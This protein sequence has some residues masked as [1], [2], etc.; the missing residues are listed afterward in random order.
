MILF[1][2]TGSWGEVSPLLSLAHKFGGKM[3]CGPEWIDRASAYIPSI[4]IGS[5]IRH[6]YTI[7]GF[8]ESLPLR[9]LFLDLWRASEGCTAIVAAFFLWPA[10]IVAELRG[11]PCYSTTVTPLYFMETGQV[12]PA[13]LAKVSKELSTLRHEVGL[14]ERDPLIPTR[15]IGLFPS[16]LGGPV[17]TIGYP[18]LADPNE[19][20]PEGDYC[21]VSSGTVNPDWKAEAEAACKAMGLRCEYLSSVGFKF[22]HKK[23]MQNAKAAMVHCGVGTLVDAMAA[24][25]PIVC[26]PIAYDQHYNAAKL[27]SL[28]A[29]AWPELKPGIVRAEIEPVGQVHESFARV[30]ASSGFD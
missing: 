27:V 18:S 16:F 6:D 23:L 24:Q 28:G 4:S 2:S 30:I 5:P 26:R 20:V 19:A 14:P 1:A 21:A 9:Q 7:Q 11:I 17:E 8:M 29:T 3:A 10:Q 25:T 12:D 13:A 15:L 22:N